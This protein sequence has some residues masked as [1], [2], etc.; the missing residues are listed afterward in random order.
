VLAAARRREP[1]ALDRLYRELAPTV[2]GYLRLRGAAEPD[3]LTSD[4]FV[5][6]FTAIESFTGDEVKFRSW[7]FTI[8]HHRMVDEARKDARRP[9]LVALDD[10]GETR[11]RA[12]TEAEALGSLG[13]GRIRAVLDG[14][15]PDQRDVLLL[16]V[17]ADL[18]ID[19]VALALGKTPGAVKALQ[20]RAVA[21]V[22][23]AVARE[24]VSL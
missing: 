19:E 15:S 10:A 13:E 6:V 23:R 1:W 11:G 22:R 18:G 8:A 9:R 2:A 16:R 17:V 3:D 20:H 5:R 24:A 4:V 12:D 21:A 14:L 7:V